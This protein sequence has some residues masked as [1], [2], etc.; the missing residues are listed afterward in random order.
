[1]PAAVRLVS[2]NCRHDQRE[3]ADDHR[4]GW[5]TLLAHEWE[6]AVSDNPLTSARR[7][8]FFEGAGAA[9]ARISFCGVPARPQMTLTSVPG[10]Q[11]LAFSTQ[12]ESIWRK[13]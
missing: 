12:S 11:S 8:S 3:R 6:H 13:K 2:A 4:S 5:S 7:V 10:S 9:I 1:M